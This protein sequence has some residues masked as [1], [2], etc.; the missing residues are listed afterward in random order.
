MPS[1][2]TRPGGGGGVS[3]SLAITFYS[4]AGLTTPITTANYGQTIY[5][6]AV[7]TGV[8]PNSHSFALTNG[9]KSRSYIQAGAT[10]T[11]TVDIYG[12]VSVIASATDGSVGTSVTA[13]S[14]LTVSIIKNAL[15][16]DGVSDRASGSI[17]FDG[18]FVDCSFSFWAKINNTATNN[19]F[20][21]IN[22]IVNAQATSPSFAM[23]YV[24]SNTTVR[25]AS[26]P[27]EAG[28]ASGT[29]TPDTDYHFY[30]VTYNYAGRELKVYYDSVLLITVASWDF[31]Y[32]WD[33]I[34][35]GYTNNYPFVGQDYGFINIKDFRVHD[36]ELSLATVQA[37][38]ADDTLMSGDEV[39]WFP[40]TESIGTTTGN[41]TDVIENAK[42]G[43]D[44]ITSPYGIVAG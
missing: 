33:C 10:L 32:A 8:T 35:L 7:A 18:R 24:S 40:F 42:I 14:T 43:M 1:I 6:N 17:P 4:D 2:L 39:Q 12:S 38:Y 44:G 22:S 16:C 31:G 37:M 26:W 13:S 23:M 5:I 27:N 15:A 29:I 34:T 41:L 3:A 11:W 25:V 21:S 19:A 20:F 30:T 36:S 9:T 28:L